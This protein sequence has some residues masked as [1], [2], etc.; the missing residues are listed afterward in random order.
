MSYP[1]KGLRNTQR[2]RPL[3]SNENYSCSP[4]ATGEGLIWTFHFNEEEPKMDELVSI[5]ETPIQFFERQASIVD[6]E[7]K[8]S[9][10][11]VG[12]CE[13]DERMRKSKYIRDMAKTII[14]QKGIKLK[15][16]AKQVL[17]LFSP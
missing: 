11:R 5:L 10:G 12:S 2:K 6:Q 17:S 16:L 1:I 8:T 7:L 9:M 4:S 3:F 13:D 15:G 14:K